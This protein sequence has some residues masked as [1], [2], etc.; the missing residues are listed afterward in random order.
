MSIHERENKYIN[1]LSERNYTVKEL[2]NALFISEPTV[3]RDVNEMIKKELITRKNGVV[4]IK[5]NSPDTRV[6]LFIRNLENKE[7]K[8]AIAKKASLFVKDGDTYASSKAAEIAFLGF[9]QKSI[10]SVYRF[11]GSVFTGRQIT[12]ED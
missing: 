5:T 7:A 4:S 9:F 12:Y 11:I 2:S 1:L 10:D 8:N 6:P 3:R